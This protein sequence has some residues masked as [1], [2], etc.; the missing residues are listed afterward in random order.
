[1]RRKQGMPTRQRR[2]GGTGDFERGAEEE[3]TLLPN[4]D[5]DDHDDGFAALGGT[6]AAGHGGGASLAR[7]ALD[8]LYKLAL[9]H[10]PE[11][12]VPS[13]DTEPSL[14]YRDVLGEAS[15]QAWSLQSL[16]DMSSSTSRAAPSGHTI[17]LPIPLPGQPEHSRA[18]PLRP[19]RSYFGLANRLCPRGYWS[20]TQTGLQAFNDRCPIC[21]N[22]FVVGDYVR[23]FPCGHQLHN[24]CFTQFLKFKPKPEMQSMRGKNPLNRACAMCRAK[25]KFSSVQV[26]W[27]HFQS[28]S[29]AS[30]W[31][32]GSAS[33]IGAH[34]QS[35][36]AASRWLNGS[37]STIGA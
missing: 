19:T 20:Q 6:G 27:A 10:L 16:Q 33:T 24:K 5:A 31:L 29:A 28:P 17:F 7:V 11:N 18:R 22:D 9:A 23:T 36:S 21:C 3:S 4:F 37:A 34:F 15:V 12:E 35:P 8:G 30:R 14:A 32:N 2:P 13:W 1:M 26:R 25:F